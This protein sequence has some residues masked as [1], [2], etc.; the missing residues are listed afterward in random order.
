MVGHICTIVVNTESLKWPTLKT[1]FYNINIEIQFPPLVVGLFPQRS[2]GLPL[3][4]ESCL[5][6]AMQWVTS[7]FPFKM[8]GKA[9]AAI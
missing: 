3:Y 1:Y 6:N 7:V 2:N 9:D 8:D 5:S 4:Q